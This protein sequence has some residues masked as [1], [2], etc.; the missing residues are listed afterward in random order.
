MKYWRIAGSA[1]LLSA[2]GCSMASASTLW[3]FWQ[4]VQ[5]HDPQLRFYRD[6]LQGAS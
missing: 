6:R 2:F 3:Q 5:D 1:I 4:A